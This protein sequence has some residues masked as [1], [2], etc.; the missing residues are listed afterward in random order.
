[1]ASNLVAMASNLVAMVSILRAVASNL[2]TMLLRVLH[3]TIPDVQIH[4]GWEL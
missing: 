4:S 3:D 1:M 2:M